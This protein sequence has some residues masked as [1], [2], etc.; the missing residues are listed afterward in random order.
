MDKDY[1]VIEIRTASGELLL[2]LRMVM[3]TDDH[4]KKLEKENRSENEDDKKVSQEETGKGIFPGNDGRQ[5]TDAQK[6]YLF[7]LLAE[8]GLEK[9]S[10]HEELKK[11]FGVESLKDVTKAEASREIEKRLAE[12]KGGRPHVGV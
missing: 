10:A 8:Q 4:P 11:A 6:R 3:Q 7:R 9:E 5:M 12:Q 1:K 2:S